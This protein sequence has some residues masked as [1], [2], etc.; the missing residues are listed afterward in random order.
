[1]VIKNEKRKIT[2]LKYKEQEKQYNKQ[3]KLKNKEKNKEKDKL[4]RLKNKEKIAAQK[5]AKYALE[6]PKKTIPILTEEEQLKQNELL[7]EKAILRKERA[8]ITEKEWRKN[9]PEKQKA[10]VKQN[11]ERRKIKEKEYYEKNKK[12]IIE[13]TKKYNKNNKNTIN[14]K[15]R[16]R[17]KIPA[18]KLRHAVSCLV[19]HAIKGIKIKSILKYLPYKIEELR[20]YLES[21]FEPWMTWENWGIYDVKTWNDEDQ[22]TW[23]WQI[24]HIIPQCQLPYESMADENFQKSWALE[25]L[26]PLS[27]KQNIKDGSKLSQSTKLNMVK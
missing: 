8:K 20:K 17:R 9:N 2:R 27:A 22:T 3:Y 4:Y 6:H 16:E 24:D 10:R 25:N 23:K 11:H 15:T 26:R 14:L 21:L 1:M 19:R 7:K 13:R 12:Y 5:K 18:I